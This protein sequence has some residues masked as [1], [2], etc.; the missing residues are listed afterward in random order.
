M[1]LIASRDKTLGHGYGGERIAM[2][3][4]LR[5]WPFKPRSG[6]E[7]AFVSLAFMGVYVLAYPW[8]ENF[9]VW[10]LQAGVQQL[11]L[12]VLLGQAPLDLPW[13]L[14]SIKRWC[15]VGPAAEVG[16][17][18]WGLQAV[19]VVLAWLAA[20]R[21]P[22][23]FLPVAYGL[24]LVLALQGLSLAFFALWPHHFPHRLADHTRDLFGFGVAL[25]FM[26]PVVLGLTYFPLEG[27]LRLR[28][29]AC[30]VA[31]G[32]F[33]LSLPVKMLAHAWLV[34]HL[35]ATLLPVLY[36]GFG[37]LLDVLLFVALFSWMATWLPQED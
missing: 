32:Y 35:G 31:M 28:V 16:W 17:W 10:A 2:H 21:L 25:Q 8:L 19:L 30:T 34:S 20:K 18:G 37:P 12:D 27:R 23:P 33:A 6:L 36:L 26:V 24:R 9:W 7:G 4:A 14:P 5:Y 15:L 13:G 3:R 11:R 29:A 1:A 22:D